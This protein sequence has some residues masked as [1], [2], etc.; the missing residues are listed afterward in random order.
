V[1]LQFKNAGD[2]VNQRCYGGF[3]VGKSP[4]A[5][6]LEDDRVGAFWMVLNSSSITVYRRAEDI[7]AP[8]VRVRIFNIWT[9]LTKRMITTGWGDIGTA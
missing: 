7:Y 9:P 2:G 6:L 3:D 5:G 1:D 4:S 8:E